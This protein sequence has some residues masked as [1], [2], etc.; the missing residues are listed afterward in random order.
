MG[1]TDGVGGPHESCPT[2]GGARWH[3]LA[4]PGADPRAEGGEGRHRVDVHPRGHRPGRRRRGG[5]R[6]LSGGEELVPVQQQIHPP[7]LVGE[8][9]R[10][11]AIHPVLERVEPGGGT[12]SNSAM[13]GSA[14]LRISPMSSS[15]MTSQDTGG[16]GLPGGGT[17]SACWRRRV[18]SLW[19]FTAS[20]GCTARGVGVTGR[21][22]GV[23]RVGGAFVQYAQPLVSG[24][25]PSWSRPT[26][27]DSDQL[28][29]GQA[30][31][32]SLRT[33]AQATGRGRWGRTC[34]GGAGPCRKNL[35]LT[36]ARPG[37]HSADISGPDV[38]AP[39]GDHWNT[40]VSLRRA[41]PVRL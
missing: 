6:P 28:W 36:P 33:P 41:T 14:R 5:P 8:H 13:N 1:A 30:S 29:A 19:W 10:R 25:R 3:S 20:S 16:V 40:A 38:G 4:F 35:G 27:A 17:A 23:L 34:D 9:L 32:H 2:R 7:Q 12:S 26:R 31:S 24:S 21:G 39:S 37:V 15:V 18:R 22:L 11:R